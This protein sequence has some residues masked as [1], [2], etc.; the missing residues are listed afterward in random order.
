MIDPGDSNIP[1]MIEQW[2]IIDRWQRMLD[3]AQGKI[4]PTEND[5]IISNS[6]RIY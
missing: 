1:G 4:A 5:T 6:Y 3:I 2:E